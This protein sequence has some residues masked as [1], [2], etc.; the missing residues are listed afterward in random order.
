MCTLCRYV[1]FFVGEC[2]CACSESD[3]LSL[4]AVCV[5]WVLFVFRCKRFHFYGIVPK[6]NLVSELFCEAN[7]GECVVNLE[8]F[9]LCIDMYTQH[10]HRSIHFTR[11]DLSYSYR[12]QDMM[13]LVDLSVV[14]V[15]CMYAIKRLKVH[16]SDFRSICWADTELYGSKSLWYL[17]VWVCF[18]D[19]SIHPLWF[20]SIIFFFFSNCFELNENQ[21]FYVNDFLTFDCVCVEFKL[22]FTSILY[23]IFPFF[24]FL[25]LS[26]VIR[27]SFP[28]SPE[29]KWEWDEHNWYTF[30]SIYRNYRPVYRV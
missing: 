21:A 24:L 25:S 26:F 19:A 15:E 7:V 20:D 27:Q 14:S 5:V 9:R 28:F 29:W 10:L 18:M 22:N 6:R 17:F 3:W 23:L 4:W 16:I 11:T 8:S 2:W 1:Y 30:Q 13:G 12:I